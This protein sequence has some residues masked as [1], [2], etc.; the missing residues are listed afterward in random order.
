MLVD[1]TFF[2]YLDTYLFPYYAFSRVMNNLRSSAEMNMYIGPSPRLQNELPW[3]PWS[4]GVVNDGNGN[5]SMSF[6]DEDGSMFG[7][8][9]ATAL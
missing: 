4:H 5:T 7:V 2:S 6:Y 9:G 3:A 1:A 8:P